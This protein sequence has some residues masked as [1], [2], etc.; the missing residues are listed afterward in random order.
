[1]ACLSKM[2]TMLD[3]DQ[4]TPCIRENFFLVD[5]GGIWWPKGKFKEC[6]FPYFG[7][8]AARTKSCAFYDRTA[9]VE[10]TK[11]RRIPIDSISEIIFEF[12]RSQV[13]LLNR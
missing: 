6:G 4:A 12:L 11:F 5:M 3:D 10:C 2:Y 7:A 1:M 9:V 13:M 8:I